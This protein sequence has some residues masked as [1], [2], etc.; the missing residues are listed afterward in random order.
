MKPKYDTQTDRV[1]KHSSRGTVSYPMWITKTPIYKSI[2]KSS[3]I[4]WDLV[5]EYGFLIGLVIGIFLGI[6][7]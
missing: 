5:I 2:P 6:L 4:N 3:V 7:F 1:S